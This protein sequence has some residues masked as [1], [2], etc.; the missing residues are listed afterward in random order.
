MPY[1]KPFTDE[2]RKAIH[3]SIYGEDSEPPAERRGMGTV[4]NMFEEFLKAKKNEKKVV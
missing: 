2:E 1:V 4:L 3:K